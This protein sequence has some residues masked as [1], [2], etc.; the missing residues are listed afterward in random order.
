MLQTWLPYILPQH[1]LSKLAGKLSRVTKERTKNRLIDFY[2]DLYGIDLDDAEHTTRHDYETLEALFT[3]RLKPGVRP[4]SDAAIVSPV[5]G[6]ATTFG[7]VANNQIIQAK[8][9]H[10]S[11]FSLLAGQ[12][13]WVDSFYNSLYMTLYLAPRHYHR[14]HFPCDATLKAMR[15]VPGRLLAVHAKSQQTFSQLFSRNERLITVF[16]TELGPMAIILIGA[17]LVGNIHT[18]WQGNTNPDHARKIRDWI[19]PNVKVTECGFKKG[20][21]L[22]FFTFGSSVIVLLVNKQLQWSEGIQDGSEVRMGQS[23]LD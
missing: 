2:C 11:L 19:Y 3:R 7:R 6:I 8:N 15:Y 14:V 10:Y 12:P 13:D 21:E 5:D 4:I 9:H 18:T 20:D 1:I 16:D 23:L 17:F 22:G